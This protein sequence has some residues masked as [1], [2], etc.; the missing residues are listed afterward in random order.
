MKNLKKMFV[1][2]LLFVTNVLAYADATAVATIAEAKQLESYSN[3]VFTGELTLQYVAVSS[4]GVNYYAVDANNEYV[5]LRCYYWNELMGSEDQL[6]A[7]NVITISSEMQFVND[8]NS[9]ATFDLDQMDLAAIEVVGLGERNVPTIVTIEDLKSDT[10]RL[11][12]AN[13][14]S[15]E[16]AKVESVLD[17]YVSPFP[18]NKIVVGESTLDFTMEDIKTA[19]PAKANIYGFVDYENGQPKLYIPQFDGFVDP[20]AFDDISGMKNFDAQLGYDNVE[21]NSAVLVTDVQ[22]LDDEYIYRVQ[23]ND[24]TGNPSALQII[25]PKDLNLIYQVGDSVNFNIKGNYMPAIYEEL[26]GDIDKMSSVVFEVQSDISTSLISQDNFV[27]LV[28]YTS[29]FTYDTEESWIKYDNCLITT[30]KGEF[31]VSDKYSAIGCVALCFKNE[32]TGL[33]DT[34]LVANTYY[35]EAGSP[36]QA[37]V[38]GFIGG[39]KFGEE[40]YSAIMPRSKNDFLSDLVEF[41]NIAAMKVAGSTPSRDISY[42]IN[43]PMA[44]TGFSSVT[45]N[46]YT[47]YMIFVQDET[48]YIQLNHTNKQI[49][50]ELVVGDVITGLTGYY[51]SYGGTSYYDEE[52]GY[53]F[54]TAPMFEVVA[55][56]IVKS[57]EEYVAK[58]VEITLAELNDSYASQLVT[59]KDVTYQ[60]EVVIL[61]TEDKELPILRQGEDAWTI[62]AEGYEYAPTMTSITGVYFL[63]GKLTRFIPRSQEDIVFDNTVAIEDIVADN[64]LFIQNNIVSANGAMIEVYDV[65]GRLVVSG[66]NAVNVANMNMSVM[67]VKTTYS[68]NSNFVTKLVNR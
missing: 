36:V 9:C 67:I 58:P 54:A 39:Y 62:L 50:N 57:E 41:D 15:I 18:I 1:L 35:V 19:Y 64:N 52:F 7:G 32:S 13:F 30:P 31:L 68:D 49:Q 8:D 28:P 24:V 34:L 2:G 16:G 17:F 56:S 53:V 48:G 25:I 23:K 37:N 40:S 44:I 6:Y 22:S 12:N 26:V 66:I 43:S 59:L 42:K 65:M 51:S 47:V 10:E 55:S 45:D 11:Y 60:K 21:F 46:G 14:V 29:V 27:A 33:F 20:V 63:Y 5:R 4:A 61:S 3:I 38:C